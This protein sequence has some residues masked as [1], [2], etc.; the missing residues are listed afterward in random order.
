MD[1]ARW[2]LVN[3]GGCD[4]ISRVHKAPGPSRP[5]VCS[6]FTRRGRRFQSLLGTDA[7][8]TG[9]SPYIFVFQ[10]S[11]CA[12]ENSWRELSCLFSLLPLCKNLPSGLQTMRS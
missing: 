5:S 3:S 2:A 4:Q 6:G 1:L 7:A 9:N 8:R 12:L 10:V 11:G